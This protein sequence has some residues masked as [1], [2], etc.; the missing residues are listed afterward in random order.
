MK[1]LL[2]NPATTDTRKGNHVTSDRWT[3]HLED[4]GHTV[5]V[6]HQ[7]KPGDWDALV[8][9]HAYKSAADIEQFANEHP[10]QLLIVALTGTDVYRD[11]E[12][13]PRTKE[14]L[15]YADRLITLQPLARNN[16]PE[17]YQH[18]IHVVHQS[19]SVDGI[20][21]QRPELV[22]EGFF[23][24]SVAHL[25]DVKDPLRL[26]YA[27][28]DLPDESAI[29]AYHLGATLEDRYEEELQKL[30]ASGRFHYLGERPR[31]D[32][33]EF[34]KGADVLVISSRLE[35]GANVV[36]EAISLGTP[37]LASDIPGNRGLLGDDYPG[38]FPVE[39][40]DELR[41]LLLRCESNRDFLHRLQTEIDNLQ[42]LA[43]PKTER[44]EWKD[45][46]QSF[47]T[48]R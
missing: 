48:F 21:P 17:Q 43:L 37:V 12:Q 26:G 45:V 11:L 18:K 24:L 35:G 44:A 41:D 16:V 47:Q 14:S 1:I 27:T 3:R 6:H 23:A 10:D 42:S 4:L 28:Q 30:E 20:S 19:V 33:L 22:D 9:L 25:R 31:D 40:T 5:S 36:T 13:E 39:S 46:L 2:V 15:D 29:H 7:Y 32:T 34:I 38:Y 8:A